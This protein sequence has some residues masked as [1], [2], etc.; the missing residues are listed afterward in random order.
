MGKMEQ[1][2]DIRKLYWIGVIGFIV[3]TMFIILNIIGIFKNINKDM[4]SS[5]IS[6]VEEN[7]HTGLDKSPGVQIAFDELDLDEKNVIVSPKTEIMVPS[8]AVGEGRQLFDIN[9]E[10]DNVSVKEIDDIGLR[11]IFISFGDIATPVNMTFDILDSE[12]QLVYSKT[13]GVI[14]ETEQV[15]SK[16]FFGLKLDPGKYTLRLTTL[17]NNDVEDIF[18][19]QFEIKSPFNWASARFYLALILGIIILYFLLP[20][21]WYLK[22]QKQV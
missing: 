11:V 12:D 19:Q 22:K 8:V 20:K 18:S 17:Y 4:I 3:F 6:Y 15:Y 10:L 1:K 13:E 9:L 2:Y 14:V 5:I 21:K 7:A 16:S